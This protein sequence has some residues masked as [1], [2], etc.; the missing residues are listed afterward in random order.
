M[1]YRITFTQEV[2]KEVLLGTS[3]EV[4]EKYMGRLGEYRLVSASFK[5]PFTFSM[6]ASY[7]FSHVGWG[8]SHPVNPST[9]PFLLPLGVLCYTLVI[10]TPVQTFS[11]VS[12]IL[13]AL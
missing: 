2:F 9:V 3:W 10:G 12:T 4:L 8:L 11:S 7:P 6:R 13:E 5:A 1:L